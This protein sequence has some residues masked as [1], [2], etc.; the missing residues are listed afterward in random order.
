MVAL[1]VLPL[2]TNSVE[3]LLTNAMPVAAAPPELVM[4]TPM[5][6]L[7]AP[8]LTL[9]NASTGGAAVRLAVGAALPVPESAMTMLAPPVELIVSDAVSAPVPDGA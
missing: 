4:V 2:T 5:P 3:L 9:P 8:T 7:V 6:A 1:H